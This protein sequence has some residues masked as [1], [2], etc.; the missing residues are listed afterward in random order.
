[1]NISEKILCLFVCI[2]FP[3]MLVYGQ[4]TPQDRAALLEVEDDPYIET[5]RSSLATQAPYQV[6]AV[7]F[8]HDK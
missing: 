4:Q 5:P 8:L 2:L 7:L 1:M 3:G 6:D